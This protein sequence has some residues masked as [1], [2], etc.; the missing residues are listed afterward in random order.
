M[1]DG[2]GKLTRTLEQTGPYTV[3]V[4]ESGNNQT[5]DYA[6]TVQCTSGDCT[7]VPIPDVS[8]C[9]DLKGSPLTGRQVDL[10]Q[11]NEPTKTTTTDT[12]G[13]YEFATVKSGKSFRVIIRGPTVP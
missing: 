8:G 9:I 13:C 3:L 5:V 10:V 4:N 11:A 12:T 2:F 7:V 1:A 6:L